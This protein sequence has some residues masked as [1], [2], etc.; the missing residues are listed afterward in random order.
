MKM[1]W[2]IVY[3]TFNLT[4]TLKAVNGVLEIFGGL[5]LMLYGRLSERLVL[6]FTQYEIIE[7]SR[8]FISIYLL[9]HGLMNFF[10]V[11]SLWKRRLW[12]FPVAIVLFSGFVI[13]QFYR[14]YYNHS[15]NLLLISILDTFIIVL[16]FLEYKR[17]RQEK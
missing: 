2:L 12:A 9:F 7:T 14:F 3:H 8:Y 4:I 11:I 6:Y 16:T 5:M 15:I 13:Y 10:L 1:F 17:L